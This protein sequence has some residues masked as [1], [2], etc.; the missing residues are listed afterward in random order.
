MLTRDLFEGP[1]GTLRFLWK[2]FST[3]C[4]IFSSFSTQITPKHF[5]FLL[6]QVVLHFSLQIDSGGVRK[7]SN[8]V[9]LETVCEFLSHLINMFYKMS[10]GLE[11]KYNRI[12]IITFLF[13]TLEPFARDIE[14]G[15]HEKW[16][17]EVFYIIQKH[18]ILGLFNI[19]SVICF[20]I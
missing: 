1:P 8:R 5:F 14:S 6:K 11:R 12:L 13:I 3:R 16:K 20:H 4:L 19:F 9:K 18:F 7:H 15:R 2:Q 17:Q 10:Y